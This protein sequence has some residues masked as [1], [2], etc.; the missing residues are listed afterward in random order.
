MLI[1]PDHADLLPGDPPGSPMWAS[2]LASSE[3]PT[4]PFDAQLYDPQNFLKQRLLIITPRALGVQH[5]RSPSTPLPL[6][7][8]ISSS[9]SALS[10]ERVGLMMALETCHFPQVLLGKR[11]TLSFWC[12]AKSK[13]HCLI[14]WVWSWVNRVPQGTIPAWFLTTS[15]CSPAQKVFWFILFLISSSNVQ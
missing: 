6:H 10:H 11:G 3:H 1:P 12:P 2:M 13:F 7:S 9:F 4:S 15:P 5:S 8:K 14:F